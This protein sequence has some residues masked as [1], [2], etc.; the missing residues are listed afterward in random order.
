M[1]GLIDRGPLLKSVPFAP[2]WRPGAR[3]LGQ[4]V[5][6]SPQVKVEAPIQIE[7]GG[8]PLSIGLFAGSGV[9]F[10]VRSGLPEGWPQTVATVFGAALAVGG[11]VNLLLPK[12]KAAPAAAAA[13]SVP[14]GGTAQMSPPLASTPEA[15]LAGVSAQII[16]PLESDTVNISPFTS[17]VPVV[18][19]LSN[20]STEQASFEVVL[21]ALEN[22]GPF[23][24]QVTTQKPVRVALGP[25]ETRDL[26]TDITLASWGILVDFVDVRLSV[27][28]RQFVG[29][30]LILSDMVNFTVE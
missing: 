10:L 29:P 12:A 5:Q 8:L 13:P 25:G 15:V 7:L 22:P 26:E 27:Y 18:V 1:T 20:P 14:G 16:R 24:S 2:A 28:K 17:M 6:V 9:T 19:R 23:G 21:E 11:A 4:F 30:T 3:R